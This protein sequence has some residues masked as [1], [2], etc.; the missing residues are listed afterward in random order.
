MEDTATALPTDRA[1]ILVDDTPMRIKAENLR[2]LHGAPLTDGGSSDGASFV[3][4]DDDS[5][6]F[7][8][9]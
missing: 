9:D 7:V 2:L 3:D 4:S 5:A 8:D 6:H 1:R